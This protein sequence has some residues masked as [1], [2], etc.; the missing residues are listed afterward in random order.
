VGSRYNE[1]HKSIIDL[2][3]AVN[4]EHMA[5]TVNQERSRYLT[6]QIEKIHRESTTLQIQSIENK[7][8][9]EEAD[10]VVRRNK[11]HSRVRV[12]QLEDDAE[13]WRAF[14]ARRDEQSFQAWLACCAGQLPEDRCGAALFVRF[15][16]GQ[17]Q[18]ANTFL[19]PWRLAEVCAKAAAYN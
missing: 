11:N 17:A 4:K 19:A 1:V 10:L 9:W 13:I 8:K 3:D 6:E 18:E 5:L 16:S 7:D 15:C 2:V 12:G 14:S